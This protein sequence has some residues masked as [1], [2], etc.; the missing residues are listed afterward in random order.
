[1]ESVM[2]DREGRRIE[3][4]VKVGL[5]TTGEQRFFGA[6]VHDI[7]E[8]KEVERLKDE[9]IS[10]VSHELRTPLTSIYG[11]LDLLVSG[12][13]GELPKDVRELLQISHESTQRLIRLIN[14]M[15][16]L[17]KIASGK[18]EYRMEPQD[19]RV[20][21]QQ[22]VRDT[23]AYADGYR[24][25]LVLEEGEDARVIADADRIV[26]VCVNLLSNAAK[27][28]PADGQVTVQLAVVGGVA[29]VSVIDNGPGIPA[30]F[31]D[32]MFQRFAQAD[33]SDRRAKG[34]TGL[35]LSICRS[36]VQ[37]HGGSMAFTSEPGVRTEF[38]FELP[39]AP[40]A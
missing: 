24:V 17:D 22:A 40:A 12:I 37:A 7:S 6:F 39:I 31:H 3:V 25:R 19:L 1:M 26:Q 8:R 34:G 23:Q 30:E 27:F 15:L 33:A 13:A 14:D 21:V 20:L 28:S 36:I 18:L 9:F 11:S 2:V 38:Y 10:T 32:R 16:D 4:E 35:G 29:R 5:V